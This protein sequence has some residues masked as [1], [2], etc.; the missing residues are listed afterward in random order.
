MK[1]KIADDEAAR[2]EGRPRVRG[3]KN[4]PRKEMKFAALDGVTGYDF[5]RDLVRVA[6]RWALNFCTIE[7][8]GR[9][10]SVVAEKE[11]IRGGVWF[12]PNSQ[13]QMSKDRPAAAYE[14]IS[15]MHRH[16][17]KRWN[18][19]GSY[20]FWVCNGTRAEPDRHD[21]QKPLI[22][23]LDLVQ[24]FTDPGDV[25]LD[26]FSGSGRVGEACLLLGRRYLGFDSDV[27]WV[28]KGNARCER[29]AARYGSLIGKVP[30]DI[31]SFKRWPEHAALRKALALGADLPDVFDEDEDEREPERAA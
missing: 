1:K 30:F 23:L 13:G 19:K 3:T 5:A 10:S 11:F 21:N 28:T 2:A 16:E 25:V 18:G 29:A 6:K 20:A 26:P 4:I 7:D 31:C 27:E 17:K 12:K 22:L 14:C 24:K 9:F 15:I 8:V